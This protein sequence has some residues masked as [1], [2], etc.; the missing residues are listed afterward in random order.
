MA[1][2]AVPLAEGLN[3]SKPTVSVDR[4]NERL[5]RDIPRLG[6]A[7]RR[8][9]RLV[10]KREIRRER[11][12]F[13]VTVRCARDAIVIVIALESGLLFRSRND[14]CVST[15]RGKNS[16][17]G[18]LGIPA[19]EK[20][21]VA[22]VDVARKHPRHETGPIEVLEHRRHSADEHL[23]VEFYPPVDAGERLECRQSLVTDPVDVDDDVYALR[24]LRSRGSGRR[25]GNRERDD[26]N[27]DERHEARRTKRGHSRTTP[28]KEAD[29]ERTN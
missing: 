11:S 2:V 20:V 6:L 14:D 5:N 16:S 17:A 23:V 4:V 26:E 25:E 12:N 15:T 19:S 8:I 28:E 7:S 1:R 18:R 24:R 21:E 27:G 13:V 22:W 10:S 3:V 29:W 9:R